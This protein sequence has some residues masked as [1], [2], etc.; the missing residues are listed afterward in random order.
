MDPTPEK[1]S[2]WLIIDDPPPVEFATLKKDLEN[3][4]QEVLA[5]HTDQ[6]RIPGPENRVSAGIVETKQLR[7]SKRIR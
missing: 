2:I 3:A 1:Q 6:N 4:I 5:K 7:I